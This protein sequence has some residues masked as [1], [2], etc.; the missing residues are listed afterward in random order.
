MKTSNPRNIYL[1]EKFTVLICM[2]FKSDNIE[3][4]PLYKHYATH[5][6]GNLMRYAFLMAVQHYLS[7]Q[8]SKSK[9]TKFNFNSLMMV[10]DVLGWFDR[11]QPN[12]K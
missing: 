5:C 7:F 11:V 9:E 8:I 2:Y 6:I 12:E 3:V 4:E 1:F 10:K